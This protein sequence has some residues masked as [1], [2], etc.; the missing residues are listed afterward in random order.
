MTDNK[1]FDLEEITNFFSTIN[2]N[3]SK[4]TYTTM[5][6]N[7]MR[8]S[9]MANIDFKDIDESVISPDFLEKPMSEYSVNTQIQ[10]ILG[11]ELWIKYKIAKLSVGSKQKIAKYNALKDQWDIRLKQLCSKKNETINKN[12]MT[13]NEKTNWI[14]YEVLRTKWVSVINDKL[15]QSCPE[16]PYTEW[17]DLLLV[18][19]FILIPPT[20]IGNY[21]TMRIRYKK[22][23]R[24]KSLK[25]DRN[26]I[27]INNTDNVNAGQPKYSLCFN[28]YKTAKFVGQISSV[29]EDETLIMV[30]DRYMKLR[31]KAQPI[32]KLKY[33]D[34][35][36]LFLNTSNA[37]AQQPIK[38]LTQSYITETL[39]KTT[40]KYI[41]KKLSCD[42]FRKIFL[43]HFLNDN[44]KSIE[45][46][47]RMATFIGQT[48][49]PT[50]METYKK[51]LPTPLPVPIVLSFD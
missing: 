23:V 41:G 48:Y 45:D 38:P 39:K 26:Y 27:M 3:K 51:I 8:I 11:I 33:E 14:D 25:Q 16:P 28:K 6:Y 30:I 12:E 17:R 21:E 42:L 19:L 50:T 10:S 22:T 44:T 2:P 7:L 15:I 13:D 5:K 37:V 46:R 32:N 1:K 20:R 31:L 18:S 49:N 29:I 9:K 4:S 43:T 24:A 34:T 36:L 47:K 35:D 40:N